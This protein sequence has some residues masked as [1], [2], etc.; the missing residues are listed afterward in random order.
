MIHD[1][2][3]ELRQLVRQRAVA[4]DP[5]GAAV[6][7]VVVGGG[8]GDV[9]TTTMAM[10]LAIALARRGRQAVFVD[11]DLDHGGNAPLD[12]HPERGSVVDVLAGRRAVHE[13]LVR[14]PSGIQVVSGAWPA[15]ELGDCSEAA[16][17]R[18]V[19]ELKNLSPQAE[20]VV[21]DAG[22]SRN[23]FVRRLWHAADVV[24]VVTTPDPASIMECYAA[25]KVL[26]NPTAAP[27][28]H[29]LVNRAPTAAVARDVHSRIGEACR[30]F[31]GLP[32]V[33]AGHVGPCDPPAAGEPTMI[34]P[35]RSAAARALDRVA[36]TMWAQL[37]RNRTRG[38]APR[39]A[40][41]DITLA[42]AQRIE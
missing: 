17:Q 40:T 35:A 22:S 7:L 29:T 14:G 38:I 25:I 24:L 33:A 21:V 8:K 4:G 2:A 36:D 13:V 15:G 10:N 26:L 34:F 6:P 1:Q 9:G 30:R 3:D 12:H 16:Q 39:G 42:G 27:A 18:F 20:V 41:M 32:A 31:L 23:H 28:I 37:Q 11:A 19:G 5:R